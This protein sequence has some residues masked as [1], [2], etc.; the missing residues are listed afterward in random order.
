LLLINI[1]HS[2]ERKRK[3]KVA[4]NRERES[5]SESRS[6]AG[7]EG[8][9]EGERDNKKDSAQINLKKASSGNPRST[10]NQS[11]KPCTLLQYPL[12]KE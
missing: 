9:T 8:G 6:D 12:R 10:S 1:F 2:R 7:R 11:S 3:I 4:K 5:V